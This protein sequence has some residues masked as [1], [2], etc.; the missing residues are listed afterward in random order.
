MEPQPL[1]FNSLSDDDVP[2]RVCIVN[3]QTVS[4]RL[5]LIFRLFIMAFNSFAG[6]MAT[7]AGEFILER[8]CRIEYRRP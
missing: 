2:Y 4:A 7:P 5:S 1:S 3:S 8:N 6:P